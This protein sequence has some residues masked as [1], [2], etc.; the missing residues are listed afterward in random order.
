VMSEGSDSCALYQILRPDKLGLRMTGPQGWS[1]PGRNGPMG[2]SPPET[3]ACHPEQNRFV[4]SEGSDQCSTGVAHP[5]TTCPPNKN[6]IGRRALRVALFRWWSPPGRNGPMGNSPPETRTRHP[7][8]SRSVTSEGS[9]RYTVFWILDAS[10]Q[11]LR[12]TNSSV[13]EKQRSVVELREE[14]KFSRSE[15]FGTPSFSLTAN[16][17]EDLFTISAFS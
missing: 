13:D 6:R 3:R 5:S 9:D 4:M 2:N 15:C 1:P 16:W 7:E 14:E 8:R 17:T 11:A 12:I 10:E